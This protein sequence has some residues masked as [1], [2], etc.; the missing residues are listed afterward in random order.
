M[1]GPEHYRE[2]ERLLGMAH[3]FTYGDGA[4]PAVGAA[5]AAEALAHAQLATAAAT[6]LNDHAADA[7]GMPLEDFH[8]WAE[9]AGV[10][11]PKPKGQTA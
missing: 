5:L 9:T 8:A 6:A 4:D 10:W 1:T 3:R 7:G 11:K 2:A